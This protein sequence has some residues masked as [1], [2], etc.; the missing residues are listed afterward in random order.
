MSLKIAQVVVGLP[1][2]GPFDYAVPSALM[3][4]IAVGQRVRVLF[5]RRQRVG[6]IV[7][8]KAKSAFKRLNPVLSCL[9]SH[10][11]LDEQSLAF[12]K[13]LSDYY[14]CSWGEA[15][16]TWLPSALR[17]TRALEW[18]PPVPGAQGSLTSFVKNITLLHDKSF[19]KRW[20]L[21][22]EIVRKTLDA[23]RGVIFLVPETAMI[24]TVI[25]RLAKAVSVP[26]VVLDKKVS[27]AKELEN[28]LAVREG[29]ARV[30]VGTRS[31]VFAPAANLG[32]IIIYEE[33][34]TA[35]K[36]EQTPHYDARTLARMRACVENFSVLYVSSA[37]SAETWE[38]AKKTKG[39]KTTCEAKHLSA[40]QI[41]DMTNYNP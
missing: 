11:L 5:N 34:N 4:K 21:I 1:V 17:A 28:W 37:P 12:T 13:E 19:D 3:N 20:S 8:F 39:Q 33:E 30:V 24:D 32:L 7:G 6:F 41:V 25:G 2:E 23:G 31:A 16:E 22:L 38:L 14:A 27:A 18:T 36:Q 9:D 35:Y 26:I 29:K 15:I 10:P 40:I